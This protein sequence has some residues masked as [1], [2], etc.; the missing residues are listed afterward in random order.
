MAKKNCLESL[1][2]NLK[3]VYKIGFYRKFEVDELCEVF[4][5]PSIAV[6]FGWSVV[7]WCLIS[8]WYYVRLAASSWAAH[9]PFDFERFQQCSDDDFRM[10]MHP[11]GSCW[12]TYTLCVVIFGLLV[13][14]I[15]LM[16]LS[17]Q[18]FVQVS[19]GTIRFVGVLLMFF[20]CL[21]ALVSDDFLPENE[22]KSD[23]K[24]MWLKFDVIGGLAVIPVASHALPYQLL[25]PSFVQP[26]PDKEKLHF[27]LAAS[28]STCFV[29]YAVV[30]VTVALH[31][32]SQLVETSSL[33]WV[34]QFLAK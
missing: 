15:S 20:Y 1:V 22:E 2:D 5:S 28:V 21:I 31:F 16:E 18:K 8:M 11:T 13:V 3:P 27:L 25:I 6:V 32:Q 24:S 12:N 9:I 30:G 34:N 19:M 33:S 17:Q 26:V 29:V 10:M 4:L 14:P 7:L 23:L